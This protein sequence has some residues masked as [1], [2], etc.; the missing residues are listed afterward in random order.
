[1]LSNSVSLELAKG[2]FA[3]R[4]E[5]VW[6]R[7]HADRLIAGTGEYSLYFEGS[8]WT[9][10]PFFKDFSCLAFYFTFVSRPCGFLKRSFLF[11]MPFFYAMLFQP[12]ASADGRRRPKFKQGVIV[13]V[14]DSSD[15]AFIFSNLGGLFMAVLLLLFILSFS[16]RSRE[17]GRASCRERV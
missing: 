16:V 3:N 9:N 15:L 6:V 2:C 12:T 4:L 8:G 10:D 5:R 1:M 17:I 11:L 7:V 14:L 13:M